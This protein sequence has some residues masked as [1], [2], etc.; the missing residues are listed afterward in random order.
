MRMSAGVPDA[1]WMTR[2]TLANMLAHCCSMVGGIC[3]VSG[4]FPVMLP[5]MTN[6]PIW[7]ALGMGCV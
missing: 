7:L 5:V 4:S 6:G 2:P 3:P 1:A